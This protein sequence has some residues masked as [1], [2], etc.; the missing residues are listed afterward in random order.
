M[1]NKAT[2]FFDQE[3][4]PFILRAFDTTI[5]DSGIIIN[6]RSGEPIQTPEGLELTPDQLGAIKKGSVIFLKDDIYSI[7]QLSENKY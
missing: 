5:D 7:I 3:S 6:S 1:N 2:L 4:L